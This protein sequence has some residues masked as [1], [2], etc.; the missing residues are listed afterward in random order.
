MGEKPVLYRGAIFS[1]Q[2][3]SALQAVIAGLGPI[4]IDAM[5]T[6]GKLF[7]GVPSSG[8][9]HYFLVLK[10]DEEITIG[11]EAQ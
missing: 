4:Q 1:G 6:C 9:S 7:Q 11:G 10:A 2:I 5:G 3:L 8:G